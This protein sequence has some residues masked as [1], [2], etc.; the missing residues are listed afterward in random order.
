M[1][2]NEPSKPA[3]IPASTTPAVKS[4]GFSQIAPSEPPKP[5]PANTRSAGFGGVEATSNESRNSQPVKSTGDFDSPT[6]TRASGISRAPQSSPA[7]FGDAVSTQTPPP[8]SAAS[9]P[10]PQDST[11][12]EITYQP[13]PAYTDEARRLQIEGEVLVEAVFTA[14]GE[15]QIVRIARG[16]GHG[17]NENAIAAV[18]SIRF[19]PARHHGQPVDSTATVRVRFELAY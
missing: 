12:V 17:L 11:P 1:I 6:T 18:R 19:H 10:Q 13:R 4:A 16:L 15:I 7:G 14:S 8:T 9:P 5:A 3:P 2:Q